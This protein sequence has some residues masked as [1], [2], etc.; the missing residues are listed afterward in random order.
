[1][2]FHGL[3]FIQPRAEKAASSGALSS[4]TMI[5]ITA[6]TA[7]QNAFNRS[8]KGDLFLVIERSSIWTDLNF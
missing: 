3:T 1:M 6:K 7:S 8:A 2:L 4:S 5:T